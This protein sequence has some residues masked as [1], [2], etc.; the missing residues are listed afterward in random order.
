MA[1]VFEGFDALFDQGLV[2]LGADGSVDIA[3]LAE[4][5]AAHAAAK[6]FEVYPVMYHLG[7]GDAGAPSFGVMEATVPS[8]L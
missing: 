8:S 2:F 1:R 3:R 7:G 5:A 4:A 6:Q